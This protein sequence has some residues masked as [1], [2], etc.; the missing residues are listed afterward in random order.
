M[1]RVKLCRLDK[2]GRGKSDVEGGVIV[3]PPLGIRN[4]VLHG[5]GECTSIFF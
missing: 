1:C 5:G 2:R 3:D 4:F